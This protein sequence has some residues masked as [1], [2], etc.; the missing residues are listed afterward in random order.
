[1]SQS[2][3]FPTCLNELAVYLSLYISEQRL[4]SRTSKKRHTRVQ[5]LKSK[6]SNNKRLVISGRSD[7]YSTQTT[8]K[9][10]HDGGATCQ[11]IVLVKEAVYCLFCERLFSNMFANEIIVQTIN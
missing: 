5:T 3:T 10:S 7:C 1:M 11:D 8:M 9:Q 2:K 4:E 6:L